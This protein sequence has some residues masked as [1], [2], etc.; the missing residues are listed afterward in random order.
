MPAV[1]FEP[2]NVTWDGEAASLISGSTNDV[3]NAGRV[4]YLQENGQIAPASPNSEASA[5]AIGITVGSAQSDQFVSIASGD[6]LNLQSIT[7]EPGEIYCVGPSG[8]IVSKGDLPRGSWVTIVGVAISTS[9]L[10][11]HI[12]QTGTQVA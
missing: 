8:T 10:Q 9:Q 3:I 11:I 6:S 1:I 12:W 4:V 5:A 2:E 7:L